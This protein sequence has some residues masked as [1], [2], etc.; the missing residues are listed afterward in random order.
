MRYAFRSARVFLDGRTL[1]TKVDPPAASI[2]RLDLD[3]ALWNSAGECWSG[4]A[5]ASRGSDIAGAGPFRVVTTAGE[6][7]GKSLVNASGRWSNLKIP[8]PPETRRN[9]RSST[10]RK[11]AR[12]QGALRGG[13]CGPSIDGSLRRSLFFQWRI[14]W[15]AAGSGQRRKIRQEGERIRDG[16]RR[17]S[18][19]SGRG[20][21]K[22]PALQERSRGWTSAER[23]VSTS[24]L[25]FR[26][27]QP[28]T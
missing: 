7:E 23:P 24:P 15:C 10:E 17:C 28:E 5:A 1:Q 27:P 21:A 20:L 3:A 2:A 25:I 8:P 18:H 13:S 9:S 19:Q 4:R 22:H 12:D 6:F 26:D 11:V 16:A 14:L